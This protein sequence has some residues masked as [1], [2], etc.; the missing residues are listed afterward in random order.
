MCMYLCMFVCVCMYV[1][2]YVWVYHVT[3]YYTL[4][5]FTSFIS[6]LHL[7]LYKSNY[8]LTSQSFI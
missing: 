5:N 1:Y 7:Q 6:I 2:V 3:D 4:A 8:F